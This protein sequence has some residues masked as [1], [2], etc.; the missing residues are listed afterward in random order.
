MKPGKSKAKSPPVVERPD[1]ITRIAAV[2]AMAAV[3]V[4]VVVLYA[5]TAQFPFIQG[6]DWSMVSRHPV[7][8]EGLTWHGLAWSLTHGLYGIWMPLTAL[9]H[10]TDMNLFGDWAGGHHLVNLF[11]HLLAVVAFYAALRVLTGARGASLL[12]AALFAVHPLGVE[13]VAWVS[14]RKDLV[15]GVFFALALL[16]HAWY[17]RRPGCLRYAVV[18]VAV[19]L[20]LAG[21]TSAAPLPAILLLLDAWPLGRFRANGDAKGFARRALWLLAEKIPLVL[22]S[23]AVSVVTW[24]AQHEV[25]AITEKGVPPSA[26]R[27]AGVGVNYVHYL[28]S[29]FWP[30]RLSPQHPFPPFVPWKVIAAWCLVAVL[31][32][33]VLAFRRRSPWLAV[34]WFWF[35]AALVPVVGFLPYGTVPYADR[36]M[37]IPGM[38]LALAVVW[39]ITALPLRP[40]PRT[41]LCAALVLVLTGVSWVQVGIWR[42]TWSLYEQKMRVYP[43]DAATYS[44]AAEWLGQNG[45]PDRA[46]KCEREA[47]RLAPDTEE[48]CYNLGTALI[49][50]NPEEAVQW[51][52]KAVRLNPDYGLAWGNLGVALMNLKRPQDALAPLGEAVRLQPGN[53]VPLVNLGAALLR[54]GKREEGRTALEKALAL[55]PQNAA[56]KANLQ[57]LR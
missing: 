19:L 26:E 52:E 39:T 25:G 54:T 33:V 2:A 32:V 47:V 41:S 49:A 18:F 53:A 13:D 9:T 17:A 21:K 12:A 40:I 48:Y 43:N 45:D 34:G 22:L 36:Y 24:R 29:F 5:R 35:L 23:V 50:R 56:A 30:F 6:D 4:A 16:A 15:C 44:K 7:I 37:Y 11:W 28:T 42:G 31:S 20:A 57:L 10:M 3:L 55:D 8:K 1:D 46:I 38:G 14:S 51:F 27:V